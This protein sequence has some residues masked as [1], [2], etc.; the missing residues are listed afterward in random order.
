MAFFRNPMDRRNSLNVLMDKAFAVDVS[1]WSQ[2]LART[3]NGL[4]WVKLGSVKCGLGEALSKSFQIT[5]R[6]EFTF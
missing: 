2:L 3:L 5:G 6:I 1:S 4:I